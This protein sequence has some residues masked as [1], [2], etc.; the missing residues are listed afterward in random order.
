MQ[1][2]SFYFTEMEPV[3]KTVSEGRCLLVTTSMT[4]IVLN[5]M[6]TLFLLNTKAENK[7]MT[8]KQK[9]RKK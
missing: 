8:T 3:R 6:Q 1:G 9:P 7:Y 5:E 4:Y 2:K